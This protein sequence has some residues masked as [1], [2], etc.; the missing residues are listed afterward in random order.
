MLNTEKLRPYSLYMDG[1]KESVEMEQLVQ[2]VMGPF[3]RKFMYYVL[4]PTYDQVFPYLIT[5]ESEMLIGS[6]EIKGHFKRRLID[7][8]S[9]ISTLC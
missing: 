6:D 2:G 4:D 8:L 9:R 5:P 7:D 3:F 1:N